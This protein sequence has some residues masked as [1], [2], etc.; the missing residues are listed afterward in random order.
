M[1]ETKFWEVV[2]AAHDQSGGDMNRKCSVIKA[3]ITNLPKDDAVAFSHIFDEM[4]D[5]AYSWPLWGAAYVINGGC[6]DDSFSDFRASLISRGRRCFEDALSN[7]DSLAEEAFDDDAWY[8]EGYDYAVTDGVEAAAGT[9]PARSRPYPKA[10]SGG[11]WSEE[12]VYEL[13]PKLSAKFA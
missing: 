3:A 1:D 11:E 6:S 8:F 12:Q 7:P 13:F 2:E 10:P 4:M 5:K 9:R